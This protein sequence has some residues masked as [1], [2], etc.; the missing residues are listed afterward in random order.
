MARNLPATKQT[1][2]YALGLI[3]LPRDLTNPYLSSKN[4]RMKDYLTLSILYR[5]RVPREIRWPSERS[6]WNIDG[7]AA[8]PVPSGST[9]VDGVSRESGER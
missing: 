6:I 2:N 7:V 4:A 1:Q 9:K 3:P 5:R 8:G